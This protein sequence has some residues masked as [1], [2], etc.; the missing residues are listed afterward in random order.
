MT[1]MNYLN[2]ALDL[3]NT[4]IVSP[5]YFVMFT[6]F[7]ILASAI[8]FQVSRL[9]KKS[10]QVAYRDFDKTIILVWH[11]QTSNYHRT[12]RSAPETRPPIHS[13]SITK[14]REGNPVVIHTLLILILPQKSLGGRV[15]S[16][17]HFQGIRA[18]NLSTHRPN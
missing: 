3:F 7:T 2:K 18:D 13:F 1:Q 15:A 12:A 16:S 11:V 17:H 10:F 14:L 8:L 5:I 9:T 4:A 6:T